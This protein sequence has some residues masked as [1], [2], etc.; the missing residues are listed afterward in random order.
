MSRVQV[1]TCDGCGTAAPEGHI[2]MM[3]GPDWFG[4]T[5][6]WR[7]EQELVDACSL[8]CLL[9]AVRKMC[10]IVEDEL[11]VLFAAPAATVKKPRAPRKPRAA[12]EG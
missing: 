5:A 3:P 6:G 12:H 2:T 10:G 4:V 7:T 9:R 11:E 8:E 1:T